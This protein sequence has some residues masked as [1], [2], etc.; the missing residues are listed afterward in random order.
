MGNDNN[1]LNRICGCKDNEEIDTSKKDKVSLTKKL[2]YLFSR[3]KKM[4]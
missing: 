4:K 3:V 1:I 2:K